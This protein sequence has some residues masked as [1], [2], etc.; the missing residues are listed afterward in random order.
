[1]SDDKVMCKLFWK[2]LFQQEKIASK[3]HSISAIEEGVSFDNVG[4][5]GK[6]HFHCRPASVLGDN[7][8]SDTF[9]VTAT[10]DDGGSFRGFIKVQIPPNAF[11]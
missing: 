4:Q 6:I 3:M 11:K 10:T 8:M 9:I 2:T 5:F 7:F 1:M